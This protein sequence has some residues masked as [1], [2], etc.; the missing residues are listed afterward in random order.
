VQDE[1]EPPEDTKQYVVRKQD[2]ASV[3]MLSKESDELNPNL[4]RHR[5]LRNV[6]WRVKRTE[7]LSGAF[8]DA[9][10]VGHHL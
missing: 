7:A 10:I 1:Y 3:A 4:V 5:D 8:V 6:A 2:I 9:A